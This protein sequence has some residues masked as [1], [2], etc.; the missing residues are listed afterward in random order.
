MTG[1]PMR[2]ARCHRDDGHAG[3]EVAELR[4]RVTDL[5]LRLEDR[6][7]VEGNL[8]AAHPDALRWDEPRRELEVRLTGAAPIRTVTAGRSL[9]RP[10]S[11]ASGASSRGRPVPRTRAACRSPRERG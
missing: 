9:S 4:P 3:L 7:D 6:Q 11:R 2:T 8:S 5:Y 10:R 1:M